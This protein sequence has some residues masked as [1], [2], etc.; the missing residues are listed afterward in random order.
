VAG[1][2][3]VLGVK[4]MSSLRNN[5]NRSWLERAVLA[6]LLLMVASFVSKRRQRSW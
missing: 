3:V 4:L 1:L 6:V 5:G 2:A